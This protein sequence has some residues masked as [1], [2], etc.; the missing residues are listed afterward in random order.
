MRTFNLTPVNGRKSFYD[1][2]RV[3]KKDGISYL[4]SYNTNVSQYEHATNKMV[5]NGWYSNTTATHI[6]AF[7]N[8]YGF[9]MCSKQELMNYNTV[10]N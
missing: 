3:V 5:V 9:D 2:C 7:L 1:K 6:N 8:Y 4:Y 10:V